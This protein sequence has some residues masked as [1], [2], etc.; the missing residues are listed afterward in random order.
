M[1]LA[2]LKAF[3][4][5]NTGRYTVGALLA[6]VGFEILSQLDALEL[7]VEAT[8][9]YED[10]ELDEL[11]LVFP[12]LFLWFAWVYRDQNQQKAT[13]IVERDRQIAERSEAEAEARRLAE[14][15]ETALEHRS[16]FF[17][18]MSHDLRTPLN[19]VLAYS[20][21]LEL[22]R[23]LDDRE[24]DQIRRVGAG[25]R[26]LLMLVDEILDVAALDAGEQVRLSDDVFDLEEELNGVAGFCSFVNGRPVPSVDM[27]PDSGAM[28]VATD[29][30]R[31]HQC[32]SN[33]LFNAFKHSGADSSVW[34]E[35]RRLDDA[36]LRITVADDGRGIPDAVLARIGDPF[37]AS[38]VPY[39]AESGSGFGLYMVGRYMDL[40]GGRLDIESEVDQGTRAALTLPSTAVVD[41]S[42][43]TV[44]DARSAAS[45]DGSRAATG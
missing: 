5:S 6:L 35:V 17:T 40:L 30:R 13:L 43:D 45:P 10:Y 31:L 16:L 2:R 38:G 14:K 3:L 39:K 21:L 22:S 37:I 23:N 9:P 41:E 15:L 1:T 24:R 7:W 34:I 44:G 4:T 20:E 12:F 11:P 29:R 26:L 42:G 28:M 36:S 18:A 25:G 19:A 33:L 27:G 8:E 32:L